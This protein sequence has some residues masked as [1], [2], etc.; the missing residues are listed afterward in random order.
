MCVA[1]GPIRE[2]SIQEI[3]DWQ[4]AVR[5]AGKDRPGEGLEF[6]STVARSH[7]L[8]QHAGVPP[9]GLDGPQGE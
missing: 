6:H 5:A 3:R 2:G 1:R 9:S 4:S 8:H 7:S